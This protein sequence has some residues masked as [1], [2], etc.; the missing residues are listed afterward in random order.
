MPALVPIMRP[1]GS[2]PQFACTFGA[3][4]GKPSPVMMLP[5]TMG[6]A[7]SAG[8]E[9]AAQPARPAVAPASTMVSRTRV[10]DMV[11]LP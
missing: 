1:S 6:A 7:A 8:P 5:T 2:C 3:G 10:D 9:G 4:F 11:A